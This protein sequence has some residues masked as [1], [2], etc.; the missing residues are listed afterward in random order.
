[1]NTDWRELIVQETLSP[2]L[3]DELTGKVDDDTLDR[4]KGAVCKTKSDL[5]ALTRL[6]TGLR[7]HLPAETYEALAEELEEIR[8]DC[9]W[10][11]TKRGQYVLTIN[12]WVQKFHAEFRA[13]TDFANVMIGGHSEKAVVFV[14]G[15]VP[16]QAAFVNLL[17]YVESK[18]PPYKLITDVHVGKWDG[19][20]ATM[21]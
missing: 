2:G 17:A 9:R 14:T 19:P 13:N 3:I 21:A 10:I 7:R 11:A 1:M 5:A 18:K 15:V 20:Q 6:V 4:L 12:A 8:K 16:A